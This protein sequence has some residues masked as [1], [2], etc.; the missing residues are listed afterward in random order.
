MS[1]AST[2]STRGLAR[3][4]ARRPWTVIGVWI[5]VILGALTLNVALLDDALTTKVNFTTNPESV[6]A[7]E[8]LET[9]LRGDRDFRELMLVQSPGLTVDDAAFQQRVESLFRDVLAIGPEVVTGGTSYYDFSAPMLVSEDRHTTILLFEMAG[10]LRDA[11][12]NVEQMLGM[13]EEVNGEDG[14]VVAIVGDA[15]V[16]FESNALAVK[17]IEQ[18]EKFGIPTAL[19]ILLLLFGAVFAAIIPLALAGVSIIVALGLTALVGQAFEL[20]FFVTFMIT[21]IGLAVGIDYSLIVVFR[22]REELS[23]GYSKADAVERTGATASKT[24]FFSGMTVVL[25]LVGMLVI[26]TNIFQSLGAGAILVV[27]SAVMATLT[28]LP[29]V[30][31]LMGTKVNMLR[32]PFIGRKV[33]LPADPTSGGYWNQVTGFVMRYPVLSLLVAGGLMVAATVPARDINTGFNGVDMLPEG[34][35]VKEAF[36]ILEEEFSFGI[37]SPAEIVIDGQIDSSMV[38]RGIQ[39]LRDRLLE[40]ADFVEP[41]TLSVNSAGDLALL[42]VSVA[43]EPSSDRAVDAVGRLREEYIREAFEGVDAEVLVTGDAAF[44]RD[45]IAVTSQYTP[46]VF[47][48]VLAFSFFL[49]TVV[50]RSVVIPIKSILLNLLSV[51]AAYGLMVLVFQ[52]GVGAELLGFQQTDIIDA[53]IPLFLFAVLFGLSMDYHVFLLSR[54]RERYDQTRNNTESVAYG[55]RSTAALIT[56]AAL[57]MVAVFSG[58]ASGETVSNQQVGFGLAIAVFLDATIVRTVLVPASMRLLGR[59]NW[60]YPRFLE[61]VPRIGIEGQIEP[62][63]TT[64]PIPVDPE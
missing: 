22:Y 49:L 17:D 28:L 35:Q 21:M 60:Y 20:V 13:V 26:P 23:K 15:S 42:S 40:D 30:L 4:S 24:V 10:S 6:R 48:V 36:L 38:Q 52:K 11:T 29:A 2:L 19:I 51:G 12:E 56:G 44:S 50:F 64:L 43:G 33:G 54:I 55:L 41:A 46:I 63:M 16:A 32:I 25:A 14:F 45:F 7:D 59:A 31:V 5:V 57:I 53:W 8:L 9:R 18:G 27:F 62:D 58:F 1:L 61:W 34:V 39:Q 3:T 37:G 47:A